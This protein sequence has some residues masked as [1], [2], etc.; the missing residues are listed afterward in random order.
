M[1]K[2]IYLRPC[3]IVGSRKYRN[4]EFDSILAY[5]NTEKF[6]IDSDYSYIS[7]RFTQL[8]KIY[9]KSSRPILPTTSKKNGGSVRGHDVIHH[10]I[11]FAL[12]KTYS[13]RLKGTPMF[14]LLSE[15]IA[16]CA[17]IYFMLIYFK[18][19]IYFFAAN[20]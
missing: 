15:C 12:T 10:G 8:D 7:N 17:D 16:S 20:E 18:L 1:K 5:M 19:P 2:Y 4:A 3:H 13:I 6:C 9:W 14:T 11:H